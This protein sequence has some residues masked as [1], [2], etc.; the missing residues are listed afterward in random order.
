MNRKE[1]H[2][3]LCKLERVVCK[4]AGV[5]VK[6]IESKDRSPCFV[7]ARHAV[8]YVAHTHMG[9]SFSL[10]GELYK[11]DHSTIMHG[12]RKFESNEKNHT[13]LVEGIRQV[14]P[15]LLNTKAPEDMQGWMWG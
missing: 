6:H 2:E 5:S 1:T 9:Y 8:W 3:A 10:L 14:A 4:A 15:E 11:R 13:L 12:V 7:Q